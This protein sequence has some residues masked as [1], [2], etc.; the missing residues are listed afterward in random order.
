[1]PLSQLKNNF[2]HYDLH[3]GN[4]LVYEPVKGKYIQYHYSI[5][6]GNKVVFNSPYIVK[7]IDYGRCFFKY[8]NSQLSPRQLNS[9]DIYKKLCEENS[10]KSSHTDCGKDYGFEWMEGPLSNENYFISS[11]YVNNSHD[12]RLLNIL[13]NLFERLDRY[14]N[15]FCNPNE[16][17]AFDLLKNMMNNV[18]Y[19]MGIKGENKIYGTNVNKKMGYPNNINNIMDAEKWLREII[20]N[21]E[22]VFE[23]N[24]EK[25]KLENK[26]GDIYIYIDG[27]P[28]R[29]EPV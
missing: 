1:M 29:F 26:I 27:T 11:Q 17:I 12:L 21:N 23:L 2:T 5:G 10:C 16:K 14:V 8:K 20:M 24:E 7:I 9:S 28:M 6:N 22:N 13:K 18:K 19:G 25:Y 15:S 4:V 3:D